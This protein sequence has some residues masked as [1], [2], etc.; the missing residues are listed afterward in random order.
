MLV[1]GHTKYIIIPRVKVSTKFLLHGLARGGMA[2]QFFLR[3]RWG[4]LLA[5][6]PLLLHV[7]VG[8]LRR[9]GTDA[10][11]ND[12]FVVVMAAPSS[13]KLRLISFQKKTCQILQ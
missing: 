8:S 6:I 7:E 9:C 4:G 5:D 13:S 11:L 2:G 3:G 1:V 12:D 10:G